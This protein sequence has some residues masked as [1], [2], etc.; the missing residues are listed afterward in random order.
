MGT[1]LFPAGRIEIWTFVFC[2]G[3][4]PENLEKNP[5]SKERTNTEQTQPTFDTGPESS[6]EGPGTSLAVI[7]SHPFNKRPLVQLAQ[8]SQCLIPPGFIYKR[9]LANGLLRD[10][11]AMN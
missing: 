9:V 10:N 6:R 4:E 1:V 5:W 11:L 2:G 3:G 8:L 7:Y